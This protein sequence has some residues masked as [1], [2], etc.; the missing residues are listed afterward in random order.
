MVRIASSISAILLRGPSNAHEAPRIKP[1]LHMTSKAS[2]RNTPC[3]LVV[4][5]ELLCM[6]KL[7]WSA[8]GSDPADALTLQLTQSFTELANFPTLSDALLMKLLLF[9]YS[10][11]V[12]N[13]CSDAVIIFL[14]ESLS[15]FILDH[16]DGAEDK[17]SNRV[18]GKC[19][20]NG[21]SILAQLAS[22]D[23]AFLESDVSK[24]VSHVDCTITD[25]ASATLNSIIGD[26]RFESFS[27]LHSHFSASTVSQVRPSNN[28][29]AFSRLDNEVASCTS[30]SSG[31]IRA[32]VTLSLLRFL[33]ARLKLAAVD[34]STTVH[35]L[36]LLSAYVRASE[37][38][39]T[40]S[41][42]ERVGLSCDD[43]H[44]LAKICV[45]SSCSTSH[46]A[47]NQPPAA[48][49]LGI[50]RFLAEKL[51]VPGTH[52][53]P[54]CLRIDNIEALDWNTCSNAFDIPTESSVVSLVV[55][56]PE[57]SP[58]G[59]FIRMYNRFCSSLC[60]LAKAVPRF[61]DALLHC[62]LTIS[63]NVQPILSSSTDVATT[64]A[65]Y[66][67]A[68]AISR[69]L[70]DRTQ[71]ASFPVK[72]ITEKVTLLLSA[73][74]YDCSFCYGV[75]KAALLPVRSLLS[76]SRS[77]SIV[78][79]LVSIL[80]APSLIAPVLHPV[81][82]LAS[83]FLADSIVQI[84]KFLS[85]IDDSHRHDLSSA[86]VRFCNH[87]LRQELVMRLLKGKS[88]THEDSADLQ[89]LSRILDHMSHTAV[90][91]SPD[92]ISTKPDV[93]NY[94]HL[95][96][97]IA[98]SHIAKNHVEMYTESARSTELWSVIHAILTSSISIGQKAISAPES[99]DCEALLFQSSVRLSLLNP[100]ALGTESFTEYSPLSSA[101]LAAASV[102]SLSMPVSLL[103]S[104][105]TFGFIVNRFSEIGRTFCEGCQPS[106]CKY[107]AI[108]L[109]SLVSYEYCTQCICLA[110]DGIDT[111]IRLLGAMLQTLSI[112][113]PPGEACVF[114]TAC[115]GS[116]KLFLLLDLVAALFQTCSQ[117]DQFQELSGALEAVLR[118]KLSG[119]YVADSNKLIVACTVDAV[120][121][122]VRGASAELQ[123]AVYSLGQLINAEYTNHP[124]I[125]LLPSVIALVA[126]P[127]CY[128][129]NYKRLRE[130]FEDARAA[131]PLLRL[132]FG[133]TSAIATTLMYLS[134][135]GDSVSDF[136]N[137]QAECMF[138]LITGI[139]RLSSAVPSS[140]K[141]GGPSMLLHIID[142]FLCLCHAAAKSPS[143]FTNYVFCRTTAGKDDAAK[144]RTL[145]YVLSLLINS[146]GLLRCMVEERGDSVSLGS[147]GL[148]NLIG[149]YYLFLHQLDAVSKRCL[150]KVNAG[151]DVLTARESP[152][153]RNTF[154]RLWSSSTRHPSKQSLSTEE[155]RC[156][157]S[158]MHTTNLV[159]YHL[160][161]LMQEIFQTSEVSYS[162]SVC[163][164]RV[165][166][167][168]GS[169][170]KLYETFA[171]RG[172]PSDI[173][174]KC[175]ADFKIICERLSV[176][177]AQN[178]VPDQI[179]AST[180][181]QLDASRMVVYMSNSYEPSMVGIDFA[182]M[183]TKLLDQ[184]FDAEDNV[185]I[186]P[187]L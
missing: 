123:R 52:L 186:K 6:L 46:A 98:N 139:V 106:L 150:V 87:H 100:E 161:S 187:E 180:L 75:V 67:F 154:G 111:E 124:L 15:R 89:D 118:Q 142:Y 53:W 128:A 129:N 5:L 157:R 94:P 146:V 148:A 64:F 153:F 159:L 101:H 182:N 1:T 169:I 59:L 42:C 32:A 173:I 86:F 30:R 107:L 149:A 80:T 3:D 44:D 72:L 62:S 10:F 83:A 95:L 43:V 16:V 18:G 19:F 12:S 104:S 63:R 132:I 176:L 115:K 91:L 160:F 14:T 45:S 131:L 152:Q 174:G 61:S 88:P 77:P 48:L 57:T 185:P 33:S 119:D 155:W 93:G 56:T 90:F 109:A 65:H 4:N 13:L 162:G 47:E 181:P 25:C 17:H 49:F 170:R 172:A 11:A 184:L 35:F 178:F 8:L 70:P 105:I 60:I 74:S 31:L 21:K 29:S 78:A 96:S 116:Q 55:S 81:A 108:H 113:L 164:R 28:F 110:S 103:L 163:S 92:L 141:C 171:A 39:G 73:S 143:S 23:K 137:D 20:L 136:V 138:V 26:G 51:I 102:T 156:I 99:R 9:A 7:I 85:K 37:S 66:M 76:Y 158:C 69:V 130:S 179:T 122:P 134:P 79:L 165:H 133:A 58:P 168:I 27:Q 24:A 117:R 34:A 147:T 127:F 177:S 38:I 145:K 84:G 166:D 2:D 114:V 125:I 135:S 36:C 126:S 183:S 112:S 22:C 167:I 151:S 144:S 140:H 120:L 175:L 41:E 68:L 40:M 97:I 50:A 71:L 54:S 121:S 82:E